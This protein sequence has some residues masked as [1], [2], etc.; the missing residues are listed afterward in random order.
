MLAT[1]LF[2]GFVVMALASLAVYRRG[3]KQPE[4]RLHTYLHATVAFI[5]A[6]GYLAMTRGVGTVVSMDGLHT[7]VAR[8]ADWALTTPL[9]LAGLVLTAFHERRGAVPYLVA[10]VTLDVLMIG[11]GLIASLSPMLLDRLI[12]FLWSTAAFIGVLYLLWGPLRRI[13]RTDQT[14][15]MDLAYNRTLLFLTVVWTLYPIVFAVGPEGL[16][17]IGTA[18]STW[19]IL[20]LDITAKVVFAFYAAGQLERAVKSAT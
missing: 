4:L 9:L 12:W 6:T 15:A 14:P 3:S 2:L 7:F 8:Y 11:S 10:I 20:L 17:M 1:P 16:R 5:A 19:Y 13:S 18:G